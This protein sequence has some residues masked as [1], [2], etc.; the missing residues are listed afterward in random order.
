MTSS[1]ST[2]ANLDQHNLGYL[3]SRLGLSLLVIFL[4]GLL[5]SAIPPRLLD[6]TWQLRVVRLLI[7][8]G[9]VAVV[10]LGLIWL[11]P[12]L[13]PASH[14]LRQ[15]RDRVAHLATV[16]AFGYLLLI[17][18]QLGAVLNGWRTLQQTQS[19]QLRSGQERI[20]AIRR[21]VQN[22]NSSSELQNQLAALPGPPL[23]PLDS[24]RPLNVL[25]PQIL[26]M[27]NST[28]ATL[29]QRTSL[30]GSRV[31]ALIQDSLRVIIA[32]LAY[33]TAFASGARWRGRPISLFDQ[34]LLAAQNS[35]S[36]LLHRL[37]KDPHSSGAPDKE[38]LRQITP[39]RKPTKPPAQDR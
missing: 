18:L 39:R 8:N 32:C 37:G 17:P 34:W 29:R 16:A 36:R 15:R 10:G 22:A 19:R 35:R 13:H 21:I 31:W 28:Q 27:L 14:R 23:P 4:V 26:A 2:P 12:H 7:N 9:S 30:P 3:F 6:P 25:Q 24:Q 1:P 11:A 38:Y 5:A 33:A 20:E